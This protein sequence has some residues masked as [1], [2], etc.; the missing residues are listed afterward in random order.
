[1]LIETKSMINKQSNVLY[2]EIN[3]VENIM[4]NIHV[5]VVNRFLSVQLDEI[6]IIHVVESKLNII[7]LFDLIFAKEI[8]IHMFIYKR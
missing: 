7:Y 3:Q 6:L 5:K 1:M 8:F 2:V 4:D